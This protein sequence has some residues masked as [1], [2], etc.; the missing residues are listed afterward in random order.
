LLERGGV[1]VE[2]AAISEQ[3]PSRKLSQSPTETTK[4]RI[5]R[6]VLPGS[7]GRVENT[8]TEATRRRVVAAREG[9]VRTG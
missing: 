3:T 5:F 9:D 4:W 6:G 2:G 7:E 8:P 1:W